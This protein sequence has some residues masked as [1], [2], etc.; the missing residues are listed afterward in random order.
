M[1]DDAMGAISSLLGNANWPTC[2]E[3][4]CK[5]FRETARILFSVV[6]PDLRR[7]NAEIVDLTTEIVELR[8]MA[9]G[10]DE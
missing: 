7:L 9:H 5:Q 8:A 1:V 4:A 6:V 2:Q 10:D 3:R